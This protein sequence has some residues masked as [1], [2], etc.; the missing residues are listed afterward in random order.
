MNVSYHINLFDIHP[1]V[2]EDILASVI[3]HAL[4]EGHIKLKQQSMCPVS[5]ETIFHLPE[6]KSPSYKH[7]KT[8]LESQSNKVLWKLTNVMMRKMCGQGPRR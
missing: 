5:F 8:A 2:T 7:L 4:K 3:G 1:Q 6:D